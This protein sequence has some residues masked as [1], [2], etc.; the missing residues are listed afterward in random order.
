MSELERLMQWFEANL[1]P[2]GT[3]LNEIIEAFQTAEAETAAEQFC[4]AWNDLKI[5]LAAAEAAKEK[6]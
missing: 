1:F 6:K 5:A 4:A 3:T 2:P